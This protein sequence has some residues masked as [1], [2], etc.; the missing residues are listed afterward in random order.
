MGFVFIHA[1]MAFTFIHTEM[2]M[3]DEVLQKS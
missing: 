2:G 3:L 1:E